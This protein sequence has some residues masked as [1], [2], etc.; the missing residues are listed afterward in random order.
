MEVGHE[1]GRNASLIELNEG[2]EAC[3]LYP[4]F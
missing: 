3:S 1:K 2:G 4:L